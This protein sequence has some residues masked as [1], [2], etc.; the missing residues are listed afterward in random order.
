MADFST[1]PC[2][3]LFAINTISM[4]K[5]DALFSYIAPG[6]ILAW[7]LTPLR[8]CMPMRPFVALNRYV[9]KLTHFPLL[10]FIY[11]Y[12]RFLLAPS[13]YAPTDLVENPGRSRRRAVSLADPA[14][15]VALFSPNVRNREESVTG[16]QK[17]HA[18]EEV[19]RRVP[20]MGT[21][22][23]QRR[24]ERKKTQTAIR[25]WMDQNEGFADPMNNYST[26]GNKG[27][28]I[29]W[30]RRLSIARDRP[31]RRFPNISE[32]RSVASDPADLASN[33][34]YAPFDGPFSD[35]EHHLEQAHFKETTD[36]DGD[37]ELVTN[38]EDEED[39]A[40][41]NPG[42]SEAIAE[43]Y[44]TTPVATR[45]GML[46]GSSPESA[47]RDRLPH[48]PRQRRA[49]HSRTLS[50]NTILYN[51]QAQE[52]PPEGIAS[53][54]SSPP[55]QQPQRSRPAS[56]RQTPAATP[57]AGQ[58]SPRR[59][60]HH[61]ARPRT[62]ATPRELAHTAPSNHNQSNS[63][64]A[65]MFG[66]TLDTHARRAQRR[67]SSFDMH[68]D[69]SSDAGVGD[70]GGASANEGGGPRRGSG[71]DLGSAVDDGAL[72]GVVPSS[73]AT[74]MAMATG[75]MA[76][77]GP[78]GLRGAAVAA[79]QAAAAAERRDSNDRMSRLMLA[80]MKT[81]EEGFADVVREMRV[82]QR[83][84]I[85]PSTAFNSGDE[86]IGG[87]RGGGGATTTTI[88]VAGGRDRRRYP[89]ASTAGYYGHAHGVV[90]H[91]HAGS[92]AAVASRALRRTQSR[93]SSRQSMRDGRGGIPI[94][95]KG[96]G[97]EVRTP[98]EY[99]DYS[100]DDTGLDDSFTKRGSSL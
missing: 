7:F 35:Q 89:R 95:L 79:H 81:L 65:S 26:M 59:S 20:D 13:M 5:N 91:G 18:L 19:F 49:L 99:D 15:R 82:L 8:Y 28:D 24:H 44:F 78:G 40:T 70:G 85:N 27:G 57:S 77:M 55:R 34:P 32:V 80:R 14:S 88:E 39:K 96:K 52:L 6:N 90:G 100:D 53:T 63:R 9:I 61:A 76:P 41:N 4:V 1:Y 16:Y 72:L 48:S 60:V 87:W 75:M 43:D 97:K 30:Q 12:E 56:N 33:A 42:N 51:P 54:L 71:G 86:G 21:F 98:A 36:G 93:P 25:H 47:V 2:R 92:A 45:F 58:H 84:S 62:I 23:T 64:A 73:F 37:D 29:E 46:A 69:G 17:D 22:R 50:S 38:D 66:L 74:Q 83:S 11:F 67:L 31:P 10:F 3:F 68:L 94:D